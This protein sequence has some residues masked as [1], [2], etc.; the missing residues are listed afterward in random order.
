M[1]SSFDFKN[2]RFYCESCGKFFSEKCVTRVDYYETKDSPQKERPVCFCNK[3]WAHIK[4]SEN[5]L[6]YAMDVQDTTGNKYNQLHKVL[7]SILAANVDIDCMLRHRAEEMHLRLEKEL[8]IETFI[9][10]V[11]KVENYKT[12][13]K[14]IKILNEK[15]AKAK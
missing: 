11:A 1:G 2:V 9:D 13:L 7:S 15:A 12:I 4:K 14:S 3:C 5:E 8:D 6:E 10:S